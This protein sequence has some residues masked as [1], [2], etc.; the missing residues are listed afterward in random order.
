[1]DLKFNHN[2]T[3]A[4]D[5]IGITI[6]VIQ[7]VDETLNGLPKELKTSEIIEKATEIFKNNDPAMAFVFIKLGKFIA[8]II[9][10]SSEQ[11]KPVE[12]SPTP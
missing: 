5:A 2:S 3:S 12:G 10:K 7:E 6:E 9:P 11:D 8:D 1:M 4:F